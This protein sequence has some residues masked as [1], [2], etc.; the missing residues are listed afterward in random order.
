MPSDGISD[1]RGKRVRGDAP[2][3]KQCF[4]DVQQNVRFVSEHDMSLVNRLGST[5]HLLSGAI[6]HERIRRD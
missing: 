6:G 2:Q 3:I 4:R 1:P 5:I